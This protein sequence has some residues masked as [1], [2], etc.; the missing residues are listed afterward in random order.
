M[1]G[2]SEKMNFKAFEQKATFY[3]SGYNFK[4]Q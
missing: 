3:N 4:A 2:S 1:L